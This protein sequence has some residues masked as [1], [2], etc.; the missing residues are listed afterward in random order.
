MELSLKLPFDFPVKD[1]RVR[2]SNRGKVCLVKP[3]LTQRT[4]HEL[5][6][7]CECLCRDEIAKKERFFRPLLTNAQF[8]TRHL[9][10]QSPLCFSPRNEPIGLSAL[11]RLPCIP[12]K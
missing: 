10:G 8:F 7:H 11:A 5:V 12:D 6:P 4:F 2:D 1:E 9:D 3:L